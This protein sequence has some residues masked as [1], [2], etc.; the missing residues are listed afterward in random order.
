MNV[1]VFGL[2]YVG[3]VSAASFAADGHTVVGVDVNPDKVNSLN[4]GRSPIVE[5][6]LD[7]IIR[8]NAANGRLRATTSTHDA[9]ASTDLSLICVGTPSRRNG[10]LD[11]TYLER[12]AEQIGEALRDKE[13][14][15]VVVVRSTVLPGTTHEVVIPALERTSGKKY[16]SG[17]GVAVNPEFLREGT[18][19]DDFR[20]PPLTLVGHNY[21]SDA[22]PTQALYAHIDAPVVATTIRTAEMIKYASNTWHALKVTFANEVGNLCKRLTID[23]HE[24]MDIFCRDE[25]LNLSSYYMK[26]GFAFGGSCLPKDVRAMQ[27]RAKEVDLEM[28]VIQSILTSNQLQIQHAIDEVIETGRK[29]VGLLGFSFKAGTDDLRESPIVILAEALL[30]KGYALAIYDKNVSIARLVGAN[31]EY[32]NTQI[33]HLSSLL[34]E[35]LD[36]VLDRSDVLVVGNSAPEFSEAL[37]RTRPDQVVLDLVRVKVDRARIPAEYRGICW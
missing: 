9:V 21:K 33:P 17:F 12:V 23:S 27:Y 20:H 34:C 4:E 1:S 11:L 28:P 8:D 25:K 36:E 13:S 10:S 18:A 22:E 31:R 37:T 2:G 29:R 15:H 26:P 30:G 19:I 7:D 35:T 5:K 24:V 6:G 3:S 32:I 16:G 14:Y